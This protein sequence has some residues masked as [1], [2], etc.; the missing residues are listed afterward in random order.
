V[1]ALSTSENKDVYRWTGA[2]R[3][4]TRTTTTTQL[5]S[6]I[7]NVNVYAQGRCTTADA[8]VVPCDQPH[9]NEEFASFIA[10]EGAI[11]P[12]PC[13]GLF[14]QYTGLVWTEVRDQF[15]LLRAGGGSSWVCALAGPRGG[16]LDVRVG[17]A[18]RQS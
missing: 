3:A 18:R 14:E 6:G 11:P 15:S 9:G 7:S 17:S 10:T 12:D 8:V 1:I 2:M 16:G 13:V 4:A 5:I